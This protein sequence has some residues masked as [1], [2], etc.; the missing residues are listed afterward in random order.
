MAQQKKG[1]IGEFKEFLL[2]GNVVDLAIA[3]VTGTAFAL[4]IKA[5]VADMLTPIISIFAK[6]TTFQDL[7]ITV[8]GSRFQYGDFLNA[9]IT[10]VLT[11]A[12]VFFFVVAPINYLMERHKKSVED[13]ETEPL[14]EE[15]VLLK[16][17]R[18][19]LASKSG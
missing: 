6:K 16:E 4:V 15:V 7:V 10:F 17:I 19:L 1:L 13:G 2:R 8:R 18:D 3:V 5:F 9:A 12:I 14:S 11:A